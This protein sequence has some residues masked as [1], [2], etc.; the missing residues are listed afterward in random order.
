[1]LVII[2]AAVIL[3]RARNARQ[4]R[5]SQ[6]GG[7]QKAD[8]VDD[9]FYSKNVVVGDGGR[10]ENYNQSSMNNNYQGGQ[11]QN[12]EKDYSNN[13]QSN[14]GGNEQYERNRY[15]S[16]G[17]AG[18]GGNVGKNS[19]SNSPVEYRNMSPYPP[20]SS[21]SLS[22][23]NNVYPPSS[24][25]S[26]ANLLQQDQAQSL[27]YDRQNRISPPALIIGGGN[28]KD[29][30]V[31]TSP[32][33]VESPGQGKVYTVKRTF[34]P[35]LADELVIYVSLHISLRSLD[36]RLILSSPLLA[37]RSCSIINLV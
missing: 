5:S 21:P 34:E 20:K 1:M 16:G 27:P 2:V 12:P 31:S 33:G 14:D 17:L 22:N 3:R 26:S 8:K 35:T 28:G 6:N 15:L 29:E 11:R 36:I 9:E 4:R 25:P 37:R 23:S 24:A 32:F 18:V 30:S 19:R 13:Q 10:G 7:F